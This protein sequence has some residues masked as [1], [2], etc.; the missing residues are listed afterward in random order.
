MSNGEAA[1]DADV[2]RDYAALVK[3]FEEYKE[4]FENTEWTSKVLQQTY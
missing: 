4:R 2:E 3:V 1:V